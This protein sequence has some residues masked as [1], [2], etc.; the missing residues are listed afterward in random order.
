MT[1]D[2]GS[3]NLGEYSL[4]GSRQADIIGLL[5]SLQHLGRLG[6]G[7]LIDGRMELAETLRSLLLAS[8]EARFTGEM[9]TNIQCFRPRAES[10]SSGVAE[11]QRALARDAE[12]YVTA[13][14]YRG[15][16]WLKTVILN[17]YTQ[18][19]HLAKLVNTFTAHCQRRT[20]Q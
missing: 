16:S 5:F 13:P 7:A 18:A 10:T 6:F 20:P 9:D 17:P 8:G 2:S 12:V 11:L 3:R 1:G 4:Q 14:Q 19:S 15:E